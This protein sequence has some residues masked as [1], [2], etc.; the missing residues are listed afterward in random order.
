MATKSTTPVEP[1]THAKKATPVTPVEEVPVVTSDATYNDWV[2]RVVET[3]LESE[4][5][6]LELATE[7]NALTLKALKQEAEFLRAAPTPPL[8]EWI[9]RG[10]DRFMDSQR[11]WLDTATRQRDLLVQRTQET[12]KTVETPNIPTGQAMTDFARQ[13]VETLVEARKRWLDFVAKQNTLFLNTIQEVI[14]VNDSP[15]AANRTRL[16]Q[17]TLDNYIEVQKHWLDLATQPTAK[18]DGHEEA[19]KK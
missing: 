18:S 1:E 3:M 9:R 12:E 15:T 13:Q 19:V 10:I 7:Q 6:W 5:R 14:G 8:T 4:Q 16:A 17:E 11:R 2:K